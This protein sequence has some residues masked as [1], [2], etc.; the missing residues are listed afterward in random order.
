MSIKVS[1]VTKKYVQQLALNIDQVFDS[2][3][4]KEN[5]EFIDYAVVEKEADDDDDDDDD[6]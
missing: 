5:K 6:E 3:Y 4:D 1:H 2:Y